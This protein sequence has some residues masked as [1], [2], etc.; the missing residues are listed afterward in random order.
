MKSILMKKGKLRKEKY[1]EK[2]TP[3]SKMEL[4]P[5]LKDIKLN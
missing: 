4:N 1:K 3:R 2:G 5:V